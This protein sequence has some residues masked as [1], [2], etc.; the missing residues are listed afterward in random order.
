MSEAAP[1][2]IL[3]SDVQ[4]TVAAEL[5]RIAPVIDE[6]G[7]RFTAAGH[8]LALVGGPGRDAML[9]RLQ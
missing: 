1:P 8:T 2:P 6:L 4:R 3:I 5:E 9:G 7:R